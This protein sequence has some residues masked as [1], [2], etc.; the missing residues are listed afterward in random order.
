MQS[1]SATV[2]MF[3]DP[4]GG[5]GDASSSTSDIAGVTVNTYAMAPG[6]TVS[7]AVVDGYALISPSLESM[8]I[9]LNAGDANLAAL[10]TYQDATSIIPGD[11]SVITYT[12][13]SSNLRA[14]AEQLAS[15]LQ[16]FAG[17]GGASTL[18]FDAIQTA[19]DNLMT[20]FEF[21]AERLGP[22]IGYSQRSGADVYS[23]SETPVSW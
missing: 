16:V 7:T 23:Y 13:T 18:D 10:E 19:S 20:F 14:S 1:I 22:T 3:A 15:Q 6:V 2:A 8:N 5:S 17:L 12:D 4:M 11:A 9:V 21:A